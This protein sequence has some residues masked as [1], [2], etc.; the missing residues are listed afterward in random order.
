MSFLFKKKP[1]PEKTQ[2]EK[3]RENNALR[4]FRAASMRHA[5]IK[6]RQQG[7]AWDDNPAEATA[8]QQATDEAGAEEKPKPDDDDDDDDEDEEGAQQGKKGWFGGKRKPKKKKEEKIFKDSKFNFLQARRERQQ[9]EKLE[10]IKLDNELQERL[11]QEEELARMETEE[12]LSW[13]AY[14]LPQRN[15]LR[16]CSGERKAQDREKERRVLKAKEEARLK[17]EGFTYHNGVLKEFSRWRNSPALYRSYKGHKGQVYAFKVSESLDCILSAS[18]D[19]TVKLWDFRTGKCVRTFEGHGKAVRDCDLTPGFSI[20]SKA[21]LGLAVSCSTDKTVRIWDARSGATKK[22][23]RGHTDVVYACCFAPDGRRVAS[24]SADRTVRLWDAVEGFLLFN[25]LGHASAVVSVAFAPSGRYICSSSDFGER[26]IKLWHADMPAA[27]A[28]RPIAQRVEWTTGGLIQ[29]FTMIIEPNKNLYDIASKG[30]VP[31]KPKRDARGQEEKIED[32]WTMGSDDED[33]AE[34]ERKAKEREAEKAEMKRAKERAE[35]ADKKEAGGF[36]LSVVAVDRFGRQTQVTSYYGGV[37]LQVAMRGVDPIG[38]F[39][40][41]GYK[42]EGVYD[43]FT[44]GSGT[45]VG[46]FGRDL[47]LG[48]RDT[49]ENRAVNSRR[50]KAQPEVVLAWKGPKQ[51]TGN[52]VIKATVAGA[53]TELGPAPRHQL[54]YTLNEVDP[55]KKGSVLSDLGQQKVD[56]GESVRYDFQAANLHQLFI[57]LIRNGDFTE[58]SNMMAPDVRLNMMKAS[59]Q[60]RLTNAEILA[61][62]KKERTKLKG[63]A[64]VMKRLRAEMANGCSIVKD[65]KDLIPGQ[66]CT[67]VVHGE[68]IDPPPKDESLVGTLDRPTPKLAAAGDG[69]DGK[70]G[71]GGGAGDGDASAKPSKSPKASSPKKGKAKGKAA[72]DEAAGDDK[73]AA[74]KSAEAEKA[75]AA[76]EAA[77]GAAGEGGADGAQFTADEMKAMKDANREL[78]EEARNEL[79]M[80]KQMQKKGL[81]SADEVR[82]MWTPASGPGALPVPSDLADTQVVA[83]GKFGGNLS[84]LQM[85]L[86][87]IYPHGAKAGGN[88]EAAR[89]GRDAMENA[90]RAN[91]AK[92]ATVGKSAGKKEEEQ[93]LARLVKDALEHENELRAEAR[94]RRLARG[95]LPGLEEYSSDLA[96]TAKVR[97]NMSLSLGL[98]VWPWPDSASEKKKKGE[99]AQGKTFDE[100]SSSQRSKLGSKRAGLGVAKRSPS[101]KRDKRAKSERKLAGQEARPSK[102]LLSR[103]SS[104][105]GR[106]SK[107]REL[108]AGG[109]ADGDAMAADGEGGALAT[110]SDPELSD[111]EQQAIDKTTAA[112]SGAARLIDTDDEDDDD[113]EAAVASNKPK[114]KAKKDANASR[115]VRRRNA[116]SQLPGFAGKP[117]SR[118][119][120]QDEERNRVA[121]ARLS[122][123]CLLTFWVNRGNYYAHHNTVNQV[124]WSYDEK[125]IASCSNDKSVRVWEPKTGRLVRTLEGHEYAVMGVTFS[126]DGLRLVS[127]GMDN[128][129][130][131]WNTV[132]GEMLR[133]FYG[134][135][136]LIYR[137]HLFRN[138]SAMLSCS[139]D[140]TLKSWFLTPQPPDAPDQPKVMGAGQR[141]AVVTWRAPPAYNDDIIA[142]KV[143]WRVGLRE[144][145]GHESTVD[146]ATFKRLVDGLTPGTNYQFVVCAVNRMGIGKWSVP[147][148]QHVT[149]VGVPEELQRPAVIK[150]RTRWSEM[151]ITWRAPLATVEGTAIQLFYVQGEGAGHKWGDKNSGLT[152]EVTWKDGRTCALEVEED[153]E[154]Q[155][156]KEAD[157]WQMSGPATRGKTIK[158][159]TPEGIALEEEFRAEMTNP[160]TTDEHKAKV[161]R[162]VNRR[163]IKMIEQLKADAKAER[164]KSQARGVLMAARF[165]G[166]EAGIEYRFRVSA[167]SSVGIGPFSEPTYSC[168]TSANVPDKP[169]V[170]TVTQLSKTRLGVQW[171]PPH[172]RGS[173]LLLWQLARHDTEIVCEFP[174]NALSTEFKDLKPGKRYSYSVRVSN[175]VGWSEWSEKSTPTPTLTG[176]PERPSRPVM[177]SAGITAIELTTLK[178]DNNGKIISKFIVKRR[179]LRAGG[180]KTEWGNEVNCTAT[181]GVTGTVCELRLEQLTPNTVFQFLVTA[182]NAHG[183]SEWSLPSIR[184]RTLPPLVPTAP[185][186]PELVEAFPTAVTIKWEPAFENGDPIIGH[187]LEMK[188]LRRKAVP[189]TPEEIEAAEKEEAA[190][191]KAEEERLAEIAERKKRREKVDRDEELPQTKDGDTL[192]GIVTKI[193]LGYQNS[194]R[195][196]NMEPMMRYIFRV[197]AHNSTGIGKFS[198]WC[199]VIEMPERRS[200]ATTMTTTVAAAKF[201]KSLRKTETKP[202]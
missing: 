147:S 95:T 109:G 140:K 122:G 66:S 38:E 170:P 135:D 162:R 9:R 44:Q 153:M 54:S 156:D 5:D 133:M 40:V 150:C 120:E 168:P 48:A 79:K 89:K 182:V 4:E 103:L 202:G 196:E 14:E 171:E 152:R 183:T 154:A 151:V 58:A 180:Q 87:A 187:I 139:S 10:Q 121:R 62:V 31:P 18:A 28:S 30:G 86:P 43:A 169:S 119:R 174:R 39:F 21:G 159:D 102:G 8:E 129:L 60:K 134:H 144:A 136:D 155:V 125:R 195:S 110:A 197:A 191:A 190:K 55:P 76:A 175:Q 82:M 69:K 116:F 107:G 172:E 51:G 33:D 189:I 143:Q 118:L 25:Y 163:R 72:D 61:G 24:A 42:L 22:E 93:L 184:C 94:A 104:S 15:R 124:S 34:E 11:A 138:S 32:P 142:Y 85:D 185:G 176:L 157:K 46:T 84:H 177:T 2:E 74:E 91:L 128:L 101:A 57:E 123:G 99:N 113:D 1:K 56:K 77:D 200:M 64:Q 19:T 199:G 97:A 80:I 53:E 148:G 63:I 17:E 146:G 167:Q 179:V 35:S 111:R 160:Y 108:A 12:K 75:K 137:C 173:A 13:D 26:A 194:T 78:W 115:R 70:D 3:D 106:S 23:I 193:D 59:A 90:A 164:R 132:S 7:V 166:L 27:K 96:T 50:W 192:D 47:P 45:R 165:E 92:V 198:P 6:H 88:T 188:R 68:S 201:K 117:T 16:M 181:P 83:N 158:L 112:Q 37:E 36:A 141:A 130:I 71:D 105:F 20:A 145:F 161:V 81:E 49:C 98:S 52:V 126:E 186:V 178:P 114:K 73:A 127:C 29:K 131:L 65:A 149:D 67:I 41:A 100:L